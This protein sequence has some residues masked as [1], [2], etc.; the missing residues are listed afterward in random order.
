MNPW[1]GLWVALATFAA[2]T[3]SLALVKP[4]LARWQVLDVPN[5]RSSHTQPTVRGGGLGIAVG[6]LLGLALSAS[7]LTESP[8]VF[9]SLAAVGLTVGALAAVGFAEDAFGL[10]VRVRLMAQMLIFGASSVGLVLAW[11]L[12]VVLGL[13]VALAGVFYVNAANFMDGV[14]G[15]SS[16]HGAVVGS[17]FAVLGFVGADPGRLLTGVAV[18]VAFLAFLPWNAPRARMF[19]GDVGSYLLGGSSWALAAWALANGVPLLTAVAPLIVY[20]SDVAFTLARRA[21]KGAQL[22]E[23]H[24]EHVY[25][26]VHQIASSHTVSSINATAATVACAGLGLLALLIPPASFWA[27]AGVMVVVVAYLASPGWIGRGAVL[28]RAEGNE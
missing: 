22:A 8:L 28:V 1:A 15:I 21:R 5:H 2:V 3:I 17:Y 14:N 6:L 12:P 23:A 9:E 25:Q 19:M 7:L 20:S 10:R 24:C 11:E 16:L 18:G 13:A 27:A 26:L 4:I